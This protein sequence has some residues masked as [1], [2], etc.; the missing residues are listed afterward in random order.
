MSLSDA[1]MKATFASILSA[2]DLITASL[3]RPDRKITEQTH[4]HAHFSKVLIKVVVMTELCVCD[5]QYYTVS[6]SQ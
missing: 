5:V 6:P 3:I 4:T 1:R 2:A